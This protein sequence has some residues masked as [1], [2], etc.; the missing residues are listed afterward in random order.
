MMKLPRKIIL[1]A[2][3]ATLLTFSGCRYRISIDEADTSPD[4]TP[5]QI[6][7]AQYLPEET[8]DPPDDIPEEITMPDVTPSLPDIKEDPPYDEPPQEE[9][10]PIEYV[11][12]AHIEATTD[13]F[14]PLTIEIEVEDAR[15]YG[16]EETTENPANT[17]NAVG[18]EAYGEADNRVTIEQ[19]ADIDGDV[20][21]GDE[22][23][24]VGLIATYSTILR[25]GVNSIFPCQ[26]L[27]V[28]C[29][30][31]EDLV[32]VGRGSVMYQLMVDSGGLNVSTRLTA[33]ML[34]VDAGWVVRRNP[35]VIVK[36]VDNAVLGNNV[37]NTH[38]AAE[39][40]LSLTARPDWGVISAVRN[41]RIILLSG[42]MLESEET[43][44]AAQLLIAQLLYPELFSGIDVNGAVVG[45]LGGLSGIHI[46]R[47]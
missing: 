2:F 17:E 41:N 5:P 42:Q 3:V 18:I 7:Y 13:D 34:A 22:G 45:L 16:T 9:P 44:L 31:P 15:Q 23:G 19:A 35:D 26:L 30:T 25:Q 39:L 14:S 8:T 33:D 36:F 37:T 1:F 21:I 4:Y 43:R 32:T 46:Y 29:E 24:V 20:A 11:A 6:I 28:Y 10:P 47:G 38:A 40:A 12:L 27:Y